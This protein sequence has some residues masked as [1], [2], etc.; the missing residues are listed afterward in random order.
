VI[1]S[2][3]GHNIFGSDV[4]GAIVGDLQGIAPSL[5]F[6][7]IDPNTGGGQLNSAGILPL[8]S[9]IDTKQ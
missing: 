1:T 2:S 9:S 4:G 7:A 8:R 5:L 3:N 6:A